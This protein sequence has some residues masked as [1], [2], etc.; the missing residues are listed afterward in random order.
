MG[1]LLNLFIYF[2]ERCNIYEQWVYLLDD[3]VLFDTPNRVARVLRLEL[4]KEGKC[5]N[6]PQLAILKRLVCSTCGI[7]LE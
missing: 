3:F 7:L 1:L 4:G 6:R 5:V 2:N